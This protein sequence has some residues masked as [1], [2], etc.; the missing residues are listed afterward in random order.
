M[1]LADATLCLCHNEQGPYGSQK[2]ILHHQPTISSSSM[3]ESKPTWVLLK[4][5]KFVA[6]KYICYINIDSVATPSPEID[7]RIFA[8]WCWWQWLFAR[9]RGVWENVQLFIP[10]LQFFSFPLETSWHT[11]I[12]LIC[13]N[14][15]T[16][17]QRAEMTGRIFP[18]KLR[19]S[20]FPYR[21][22]HYAWT[23]A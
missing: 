20:S 16:V 6:Y 10:R 14:Q 15:S 21:F 2:C 3:V 4:Q 23:V 8:H 7:I 5:L 19:V 18:D 11:P 9:L 13:Q 12:P 1:C 17:A 22:P